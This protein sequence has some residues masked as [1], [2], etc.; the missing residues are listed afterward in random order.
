MRIRLAE[1]FHQYPRK[2]VANAKQA[3]DR[4]RRSRF[5]GVDP[6]HQEQHHTF[7]E[8]LIEL[9]RMARHAHGVG[10]EDHGPGHVR[11]APPQFAVDEI[12][13][14]AGTQT[15]GH[16]RHGEIRHLKIAF[17]G[18]A[19]EQP[20]REQHTQGAAMEAHAAGPDLEQPQRVV[21]KP[22]ETIEQNVAH[23]AAEDHTQRRVEQQVTDLLPGPAAAGPVRSR[24]RQPPAAGEADHVHHPVPV[25]LQRPQGDQHGID[26]REGHQRL[27]NQASVQCR[28]RSAPRRKYASEWRRAGGD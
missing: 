12:A 2:P 9:G 13:E 23:A 15:D 8:K 5:G 20:E 6:Q 14:T 4:T 28:S 1:E 11:G 22:V 19:G 7:Q 21:E 3:G 17:A 27:P 24:L 25:N 10:G 16:H 18:A 26:L